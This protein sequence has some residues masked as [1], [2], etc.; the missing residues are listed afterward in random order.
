MIAK[1][2]DRGFRW[3]LRRQS[4]AKPPTN[5][6]R[7]VARRQRQIDAGQIEF[8]SDALGRNDKHTTD[9]QARKMP[10]IH[11]NLSREFVNWMETPR[12]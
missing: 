10:I 11:V 9:R 2:L 7:E 3:S 8:W 6:K 12:C 4:W 5:G 1:T